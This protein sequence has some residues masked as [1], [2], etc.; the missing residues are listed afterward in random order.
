MNSDN[1]NA[2]PRES[3]REGVERAGFRGQDVLIVM[4]RLQ[5]GMEVNPHRMA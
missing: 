4:N 1:C 3:V 5:P 2:L